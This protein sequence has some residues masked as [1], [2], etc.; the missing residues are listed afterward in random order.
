MEVNSRALGQF[1]VFSTY[2]IFLACKTKLGIYLFI[3]FLCLQCELHCMQI[4]WNK[5]SVNVYEKLS[6][7]T[8]LT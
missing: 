8:G 1:T 6:N 5:E 4:D 3:Y 2:L 7:P